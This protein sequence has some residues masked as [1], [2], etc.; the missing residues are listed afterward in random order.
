MIDLNDLIWTEGFRPKNVDEC[1]LPKKLKKHIKS[2]IKKDT[3]PNMIFSG[4]QGSGKTSLALAICNELGYEVLMINGSN[5]GRLIET[6]RTK[7]TNFASSMSLD[8]SKKCV[9]L[10]EADY[11]PEETVQ[12]ALRNFIEEYSRAGVV[13]IFTCNNLTRIIEPLQSRCSLI[14]FNISK[15]ESMDMKIELIKR[16]QFILKQENI[17]IASDEILPKLVQKFF[18][19]I[20]RLINHLQLTTGSGI[21]DSSALTIVEKSEYTELV[22]YLKDKNVK[23][24]REWI[25]L[26]SYIGVPELTKFL[27]N[28]MYKISETSTMAEY[29]TILADWNYKSAF[30]SDKEI[31]MA[32]LVVDLMTQINFKKD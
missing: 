9:I 7:I 24:A 1:I 30:M 23:A 20:R 31:A 13:F 10:D 25:A 26:Q 19:D 5:E 12:P 3:I 2:L 18:P 15:D 29:I 8:G 27:Y 11:I 28:E 32:A 4:I 21:L 16:L 17:T 14:D 6:L 22:Q